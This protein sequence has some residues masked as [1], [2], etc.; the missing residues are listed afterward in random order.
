VTHRRRPGWLRHAGRRIGAALLILATLAIGHE[1]TAH[2][3]DRTVTAGHFLRTGGIGDRVESLEIAATIVD[4]RGG[5]AVVSPRDEELHTSG[6]WIVVRTRLETLTEPTLVL[7][8][9]IQDRRGRVYR[10]SSRLFQPLS[11]YTLQPGIPVEG[12]IA[13]EVARDS[14]PGAQLRLHEDTGVGYEFQTMI[15]IDLSLDEAAMTA[16]LADDAPVRIGEPEVKL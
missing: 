13:F 11:G 12:D 2:I 1:V 9:A 7:H 10:E 4:V 6:M 3:P 8:F 15:L 5:R 16:F 14:V